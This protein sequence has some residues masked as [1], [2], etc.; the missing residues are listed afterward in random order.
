MNFEKSF[1]RL[2]EILQKMNE[3]EVSL[4]DSLKL[5]E[6]ADKLIAGCNKKLAQ[7]EQ[8]IEML[9]KKRE[10]ELELDED[11]SPMTEEFAH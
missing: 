9:I 11:Q 10:G 3:G 7:A 8:K 5:Y 4:D 2:E 1:A 6:E